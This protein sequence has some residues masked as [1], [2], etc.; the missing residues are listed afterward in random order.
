MYKIFN[1]RFAKVFAFFL[2]ML[3]EMCN[4]YC[5]YIMFEMCL[6][7]LYKN[8]M[9]SQKETTKSTIVDIEKMVVL[10]CV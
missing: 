10:L 5:I 9:G 7:P 1:I 6:L 8:Y 3:I 4:I 2:S